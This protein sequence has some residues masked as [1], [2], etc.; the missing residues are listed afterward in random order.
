MTLD[1][2]A[3]NYL[4]VP[5]R[6]QGR[7]TS[8][9]IDC[10]GLVVLSLRDCGLPQAD[11]DYTGYSRDPHDG[12]LEFHLREAFGPPVVKATLQAGDVV[13]IDYK[14]AVRHV[15]V[16]GLHRD[17]GLSLIHTNFSV[18]QVTEAGIDAKWMKRIKGVYRVG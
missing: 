10:V 2:A 5:F 1:E 4:G 9:G 12:V 16:V 6:H 14:G 15:G 17:G 18:K 13:A 7:D 8:I 3:R 11:L